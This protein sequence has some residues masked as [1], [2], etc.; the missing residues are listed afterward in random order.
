MVKLEVLLTNSNADDKE[1][2]K[3]IH[4]SILDAAFVHLLPPP[5]KKREKKKR[6]RDY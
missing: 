6:A 4:I 1:K 3:I 2:K 5:P